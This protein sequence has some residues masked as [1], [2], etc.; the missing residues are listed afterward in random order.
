M[1]SAAYGNRGKILVFNIF[2]DISLCFMECRRQRESRQV[3]W[4]VLATPICD[5]L[6]AWLRVT[7][8]NLDKQF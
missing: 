2:K 8:H 7:D 3:T 1:P 4:T 6:G 5:P